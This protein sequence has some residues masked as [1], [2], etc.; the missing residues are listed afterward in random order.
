LPRPSYDAWPAELKAAMAAAVREAVAHQRE[1]AVAEEEKALAEI[2][3]E[4]CEVL[5]LDAAEHAAFVAAVAP[6]RAEAHKLYPQAL[7]S[8]VP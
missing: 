4:G 6:L 2:K 7:L 8:L 1:L 5:E 3:R